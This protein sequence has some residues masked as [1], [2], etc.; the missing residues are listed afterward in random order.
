MSFLCIR[1]WAFTDFLPNF[2]FELYCRVL[3]RTLDWQLLQDEDH[4]G[5]QYY[6]IFGALEI[7]R[8]RFC[9]GLQLL[10]RESGLQDLAS[11]GPLHV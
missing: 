3:Y 8:L 9:C 1:L 6:N 10:A 2:A 4:G 11:L 5:A 7:A